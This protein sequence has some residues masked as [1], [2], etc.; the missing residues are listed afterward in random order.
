MEKQIKN[1]VNYHKNFLHY[2]GFMNNIWEE[3]AYLDNE[4]RNGVKK[5]FPLLQ[6][7]YD[8]KINKSIKD[9]GGMRA[10]F[11]SGDNTKEHFIDAISLFEN[12][13][14]M[15]TQSVFC[16][17]PQRMHD[18]GMDVDKLFNVIL[19][20]KSKEEII[21]CIVEEKV[22]GIFY[23]KPSDIFLKDKCNLGINNLFRDTYKKEIELY[24]EIIGRRNIIIHNLGRVDQKYIRENPTTYSKD[25]GTKIIISEPYLRGTIALL[26]GIAAI[27]TECVEVN[28]YGEEAKGTLKKAINTFKRCC[29]ENWYDKLL[30]K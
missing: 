20:K 3:Y 17:Q 13:I 5:D 22:R 6:L 29:K 24:E 16:D 25:K 8:N 1:N 4:I 21:E 12:Y 19:K 18:C 9:A 7:N 15:L 26:E 23:G 2:R 11:I 27:T 28:I 30:S 14:A 10:K